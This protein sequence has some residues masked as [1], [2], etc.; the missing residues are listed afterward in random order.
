MDRSEILAIL[1][2]WNFWKK[3]LDT[4]IE[5]DRYLDELSRKLETGQV[6]VI[7][8]AR[9]SGK[10]YLMRQFAQRMIEEG[11]HIKD[12]LMI[13]FDDPRLMDMNSRSLQE[14]FE[15]YVEHM[16]PEDRPYVLLDEVQEV[17]EW[18]KWV[19]ASHELGKA[20][21]IVTGSNARLLSGELATVLTGRH[22]DLVV[23]PL[24]FREFL[25]F[26]GVNIEDELDAVARRIEVKRL[27]RE[28]LEFG[29]FPRVV[30]SKEKSEILLSYF[31]DVVDRD[32]IQRFRVRKPEKL[33]ALAKFY[34]TNIA[35]PITFNSLERHTGISADTIERFSGN[36][37]SS[38]LVSFLR[39]FSFKVKEHDKSPR[40]VYSIDTGLAN[41]VGFRFSEN[42]GRL[43]ENLVFVELRRRPGIELFYWKDVRHHEVDFVVKEGPRIRQLIQVC[44][45][46][47]SYRVKERELRA[48]IQAGNELDCD[49]LLVI[50]EDTDS[51]ETVAGRNVVFTSLWRWLLGFV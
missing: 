24:S 38:Y 28:Y 15:T 14:M 44:W 12:I 43:A 49:D 7:M 45:N 40:K 25:L 34:L 35:S 20:R 11:I 26:N 30:L 48:L 19:Q 2:D 31:R 33:R 51:T 37:E 32:L 46:P 29:G 17:R 42:R 27:L 8:G 6:V 50:T 39:R 18:E 9:R 21:I 1:E 10:S 3:S 22:L 4:G 5:R 41:A 47:R 13:N 36:L 16:G 23:F